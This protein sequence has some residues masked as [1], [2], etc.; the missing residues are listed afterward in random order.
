MNAR[1]DLDPVFKALADPSRRRLL[2]LL[3]D[4]PRNTG[5]L[6][7]NFHTTRFAVMKHL[8]VLESAGLVVQEALGREVWHTLNA[9][10][11]RRIYE[12]WISPYEEHWAAS[13]TALKGHVESKSKGDG[14]WPRK[15]K[16]HR[17]GSS[18][19]R[20]SRK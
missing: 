1:D 2:D 15:R 17:R 16:S 18:P 20:S 13:L 6:C 12:R 3:R 14:V 5:D 7:S 4:G 8:A 19:F 10:P 11:I 9:T